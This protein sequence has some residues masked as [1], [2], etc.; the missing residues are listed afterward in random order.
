MV[1]ERLPAQWNE[2]QSEEETTE[3][4]LWQCESYPHSPQVFIN[5]IEAI[6]LSIS[7]CR[8]PETR[9]RQSHL[10]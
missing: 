7:P 4:P 3:I 6:A 9:N 1:V 2:G 8:A 10:V 5:G